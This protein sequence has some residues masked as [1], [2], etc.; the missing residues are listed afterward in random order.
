M[1]PDSP[2]TLTGGLI[3]DPA[4]G[5]S[6][7]GDLFLAA[8]HVV[9]IAAPGEHPPCGEVLDVGGLVV[10]PGLVDL[11]VHLREP[12]QTHKETIASGTRAAVAGGFTTVCCMPNTTPPLD[13]PARVAALQ[14]TIAAEAVCRVHVIGAACLDN[15]PGQPADLA[16]LAASGCVAVTDDAFPLETDEQRRDLLCRAAAAGLP[17]IAH[18]EDRSLSGGA[19]VNAGA[20]SAQLGLSGQPD[21]AETVAAEAWLRLGGLGARLHLAHVSTAGTVAALSRARAT[22]V[23]RLSAETAPHYFALT[24]AAVLEHGANAKMNPPL[25]SDADREAV[26]Q[27]LADGLISIVATDHAP[28]SPAEKA[29]GLAAAPF[30]VVGLETALGV[31]LTELYHSGLMS[32][33]QVI[34]CL[35]V[36]PVRLLGLPGGY[37]APGAAADVCVF[38]PQATWVVDPAEFRSLGRNSPFAGRELRGKPWATIVGGRVAWREGDLL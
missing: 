23:G 28:H 18:C 32:L 8:G 34:G 13:R 19:A 37:L 1:N 9:G 7:L 17:F 30:G 16:S 35:T 20:V 3:L 36:N 29:A 12:G 27:A 14:A 26:R 24:E 10:C 31:A 2:L 15:V 4:S 38:D 6:A 11:H 5:F 33:S 21:A 25:R 22:W